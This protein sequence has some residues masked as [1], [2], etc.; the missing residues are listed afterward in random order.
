MP[1]LC[2]SQRAS[3][4]MFLLSLFLEHPHHHTSSLGWDSFVCPFFQSTSWPRMWC[5]GWDLP[6]FWK[7]V[8]AGPVVALLGCWMLC[9]YRNPGTCWGPGTLC[10]QCSPNDLIQDKVCSLSP[11]PEFY[12]F[13][14]WVW[15][16]LSN[17]WM[18]PDSAPISQL[19][20]SI[21]VMTELLAP[22]LVWNSCSDYSSA[23]WV[24][25]WNWND[26][27][28]LE[29]K[30]HCCFLLRNFPLSWYTTQNPLPQTVTP[31]N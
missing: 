4:E 20:S 5:Y 8:W 12:K 1:N 9:Y 10:F 7:K 2:F 13:P 22:T 18:L 3:L 21:G 14:T 30:L 6:Q 25:Y 26:T 15:I 11:W 28:L 19:E 23:G 24:R 16:C 31:R 27:L 17:R 29:S